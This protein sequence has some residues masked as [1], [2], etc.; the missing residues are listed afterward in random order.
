MV[1]MILFLYTR[2][3]YYTFDSV[4]YAYS[5]WKFDQTGDR[6]ALFHPHHLLFNLT[7]WLL[8][9]LCRML[10]YVGGP[11]EVLKSMNAILGGIG[12]GLLNLTLRNVLTR[13]RALALLSAVG[14]GLSFGYWI[15]A[16]DGRV[17]M[18]SVVMLIAA[19]YA[20]VVTMQSPTKRRA[21]ATGIVAALAV[22]YHESAGLF[23]P[24]AWLGIWLADYPQGVRAEQSRTRWRLLAVF[25]ATWL[26][27]TVIPYL[28]VGISYLH[29]TSVDDYKNWAAR[30]A[31]L[32]W[33]WD[34]RILHNLRLD[35]YAIRKCLFTEPTGKQGTFYIAHGATSLGFWSYVSVLGGWLLASYLSLIALPLL[36]K[37]HYRRTIAVMF[38]WL[39][40]NTAFFTVWQ[41][42]Y[43]VFRVPTIMG[44]A[45]LMAI[46]WSHYRAQRAG[47]FWL[48]AIGVWIGL[49]GIS[50]YVLSIG[51]HADPKGNPYTAFAE[52]VRRHTAAPDL[53]VLPGTGFGEPDEVYIPYFSQRDVFS[54][55]TE[56]AHHNER[57]DEMAQALHARMDQARA[58]GGTVYLLDD[59]YEPGLA[60]DCLMRQH[61][62]TRPMLLS[63][64]HPGMRSK[65]WAN[66]SRGPVW[67]LLPQPVVPD[68]A[69]APNPI[70]PAP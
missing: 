48:V 28:T 21:F 70:G 20:L 10:G 1:F 14:V 5:I 43:F 65:A 7:G 64:F 59:L 50:N 26:A 67:R 66:H 9:R 58:A 18:M 42:S 32:G 54:I 15:C 39:F 37:T 6:M 60:E 23:L 29:L 45:I 19:F 4:S 8:W 52:D 16:T 30:Y 38:A 2:A 56:M 57:F 24:V 27:L 41:P 3:K 34:F 61:G 36:V 22:L 40:V 51:P 35:A 13:S 12:I 63:L 31:I 33:W 49:Y 62:I 69:A 46:V 68:S 53:I 47:R 11:L 17:N 44:G 55:H 25:T